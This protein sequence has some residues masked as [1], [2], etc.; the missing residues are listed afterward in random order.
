MFNGGESAL[1]VCIFFQ[2]IPTLQAVWVTAILPYF[3]LTIL[4]IRGITLDGSIDGIKYYLYPQ[5]DRLYDINVSPIKTHSL[6]LPLSPP[7]HP[8]HLGRVSGQLCAKVP[9]GDL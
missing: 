3:L 6:S 4:L 8:T 5:W 7:R 9:V 1:T 2:S